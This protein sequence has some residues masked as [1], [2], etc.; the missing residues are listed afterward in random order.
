M[1]KV[2]TMIHHFT[3]T[4]HIIGIN[5]IKDRKLPIQECGEF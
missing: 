4:K 1:K 5:H 3:Y 2:M